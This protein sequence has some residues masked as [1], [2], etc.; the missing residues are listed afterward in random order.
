[1]I[2][3]PKLALKL[4]DLHI[5]ASNS[6]IAQ[7]RVSQISTIAS[8][9]FANLRFLFFFG[10]NDSQMRKCAIASKFANLENPRKP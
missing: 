2:C 3:S 10:A 1:M 5:A 8:C 9:A 6:F 7:T 4:Q